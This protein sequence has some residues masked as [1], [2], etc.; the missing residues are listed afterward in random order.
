MRTRDFDYELPPGLIAQEPAARRDEARMLVVERQAGIFHHRRVRDL[1]EWLQAGDLLV[2]NNTRVIPARVFGAKP[3]GGKTC[4][5]YPKSLPRLSAAFSAASI[6][7][8]SSACRPV[9]PF[10][11][12]CGCI[13]KR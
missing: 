7:P 3:T 5:V 12:P 6:L 10:N 11:S 13:R 2:A 8:C 4:G 9:K 1:P